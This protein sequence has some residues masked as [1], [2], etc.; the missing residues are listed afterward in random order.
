MEAA[1]HGHLRRLGIITGLISLTVVAGL[2]EAKVPRKLQG[3]IFFTTSEIKDQ[4]P[5]ALV[6]LFSGVKPKIQLKRGKKG[7]WTC[8]MVAFFRKKSHPGPIT[9]WMYD[10]ADKAAIRAKEATDIKSVNATE[11]TAFVHDLDIS[12][13]RGF[14]KGHSYLIWV[15]QIIGKRSKIYARG[16]VSLLP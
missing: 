12:P 13:D 6:R 10:K 4:A 16:E 2:A 7:H 5:A 8:T 15:G 11:T 14:N 9:L 3:K 1:M